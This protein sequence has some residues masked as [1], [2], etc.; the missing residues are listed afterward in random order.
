MIDN[1]E[2][3]HHLLLRIVQVL[4]QTGDSPIL[5]VMMITIVNVMVLIIGTMVM[6]ITIIIVTMVMMAVL[7]RKILL[8]DDD[9]ENVIDDEEATAPPGESVHLELG[10]RERL[11]PLFQLEAHLDHWIL[12]KGFQINGNF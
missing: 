1:E 5:R 4:L 6:M 7:S 10:C 2:G 8:D 12:G 3:S 11:L 9:H